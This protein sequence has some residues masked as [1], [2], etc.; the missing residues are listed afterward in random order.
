M[1]GYLSLARNLRTVRG[2]LR[3]LLQD[4]LLSEIDEQ[5]PLA[6]HIPCTFQQLDFVEGSFPPVISCGRRKL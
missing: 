6:R 1:A 2:F 5:L 3:L 4:C